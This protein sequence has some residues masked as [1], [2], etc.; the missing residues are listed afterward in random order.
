M[1]RFPRCH[2]RVRRAAA[3]A[4]ASVAWPGSSTVSTADAPDVFGGNLSGLAYQPSGAATPGV[5][6]AVR[7]SPS[8]LF[9]L[10]HD[11]TKWT[12][13]TANGWN[14]GK[15]LV[16]PNGGGVPDAEGVTLAG[17]DANSIYV[18]IE[19]NDS[20]AAANVSR[21]AVLRYDLTA[22]GNTLAATQ[23][24]DLTVDLPGLGK[25][26][27]LEAITWIPTTCWSPRA[28]STRARAPRTTRRPTPTTARA[29]S[30]SASSNRADRRLRPN[31][32][33]SGFTR[34]AT[35]A[36]GFPKI[37][38]LT[39]EPEAAMLW[40]VCDNDC[41]GR[42]ATL[43]VKGEALRRHRG[44][45]APR[46]HGEPQQRGL[47]DRARRPSAST[48]SSRSST[49]TTTTP[50]GTRCA[51]APSTA[52]RSPQQQQ[53][54]PQ[55]PAPQSFPQIPAVTPRAADATLAPQVKLALKF[56]KAGQLRATITLDERA[57][58][59]ITAT[60]KRRT[61]VK[62]TRKG[63]AAGKRTLTLGS[64]RGVRRGEKVTLTVKARDAGGNV[65]TERIT[66]KVR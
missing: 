52:R 57:D 18:S 61:V 21:P 30:S 17:G 1:A 44:L 23:E 63:V 49:P 32:K 24:W 14:A 62:T 34:V 10:T 43:D 64:K 12:P 37:M 7:N 47:R 20:G 13:D 53:Q 65:T 4:S 58:L 38:E 15:T 5:L 31:D 25:N 66:A 50:P 35:V 56:T 19:R 2:R 46:R 54:A 59:T 3:P 11:G 48:A 9:R 16:F 39:Y 55:A 29:C 8:T 33:T 40:A 51:P 27:G 26:G 28:Y 6:W 22:A 45:R 41:N 36:S 42:T 60:A